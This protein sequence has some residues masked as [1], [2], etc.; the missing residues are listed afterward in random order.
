MTGDNQAAANAIA[1][2][3]GVDKVVAETLPEEK[4]G[5]IRQMQSEGKTVMMVGDGINDAPALA[6]ADIGCA[7]E[8]AAT[9]PLSPLR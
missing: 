8:T 9:L 5:V 6:Q 3:V 1:A 4:A 2:Q 7:I